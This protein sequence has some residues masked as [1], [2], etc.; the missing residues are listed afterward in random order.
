MNKA[1]TIVF[2]GT[3]DFAVPSLK[4][5]Y[6]NNYP[7]A[8][9]ITIPDK[10]AGRG[11]KLTSSPVKEYAIA[12]NLK[13]LQPENLK[14]ERF[15]NELKSLNADMFV[16]VAFRILPDSSRPQMFRASQTTAKGGTSYR[17]K[18]TSKYPRAKAPK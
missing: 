14:D 7:I 5:L 6:E 4:I 8:A 13:L 17:K 16:V 10:P 9:V 3:P 1:P 15:I 2:F 18:V 12:N 11:Q